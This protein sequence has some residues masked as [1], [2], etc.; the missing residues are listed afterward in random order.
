[1]KCKRYGRSVK[2]YEE[3]LSTI[4]DCT[5][6]HAVKLVGGFVLLHTYIHTNTLFILEIFRVAVQLISSRK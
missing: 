2:S 6:G 1:M 5:V 3:L 4:P